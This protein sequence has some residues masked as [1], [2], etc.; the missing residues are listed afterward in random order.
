MNISA[1]I[2]STLAVPLV[3]VFGLI[4]ILSTDSNTTLFLA[5]NSISQHTGETLWAFITLLGDP[6]V[7]LCLALLLI[8]RLPNVAISIVPAVIIGSAAVFPLKEFFDTLRP[9]FVVPLAE[10][11]II[12]HPPA[13]PAFPSGHT[14]GIFLL[15]SLLMFYV[16]NIAL[17]LIIFFIALTIGMARI[18]VG[19]HWPID[20]CGGIILG[21]LCAVASALITKNWLITNNVRHLLVGIL[22]TASLALFFMNT[23]YPQ[24]QL[25]QWLIVLFG[26]FVTTKHVYL[27]HKL[28]KSSI[29]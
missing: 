29:D 4:L 10:F 12:G 26:L 16:N 7:I 28:T 22:L 13:S 15:A 21:W 3:G 6:V 23:G 18:V 24:A 5:V 9:G 8:H 11:T 14:T 17:K 27:T 2:K 1:Q 19:A 25:L 20:V